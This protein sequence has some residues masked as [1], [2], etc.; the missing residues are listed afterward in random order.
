MSDP[1]EGLGEGERL[2]TSTCCQVS[3]CSSLAGMETESVQ[4]RIQ[5][6]DGGQG[7]VTSVKV[8]G[9]PERSSPAW[10][11]LFVLVGDAWPNRMAYCVYGCFDAYR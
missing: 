9:L 11:A 4:W 5:D 6:G 3:P 2:S 8:A 1:L 10:G 7:R